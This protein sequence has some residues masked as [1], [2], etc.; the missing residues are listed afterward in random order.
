ME[1]LEVLSSKKLCTQRYNAGQSVYFL[2]STNEQVSQ[3]GPV[4]TEQLTGDLM[5]VA[6]VSRLDHDS[7][8]VWTKKLITYFESE[9][10]YLVLNIFR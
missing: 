7:I 2:P 10:N 4:C 3:A 9:V 6:F 1:V 5:D 8:Q